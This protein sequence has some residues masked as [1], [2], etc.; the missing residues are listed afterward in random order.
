MASLRVVAAF[1][2]AVLL[3]LL[4]V[5]SAGLNGYFGTKSRYE[6]VNPYLVRDPLSLGPAAVGSGLPPSCA[7]LQLRAL[8]RHG[9]RYP[10][11]EQIRRLGDLHA[12]LLRRRPAAD[13]G[14]AAAACPVAADLA[15]W[16]MWY[17]ESLD[18]RLAPQG[19]RDME[20]L[21]RRLAAR[22][23]ALFAARRRLVLASSS[24]HRCLQS[25]AAFRRGLGP[26]F[27][28]G[29]DE[30]E[31]EVND[32][33]MRFFD[34]CA[35]F[36]A[37]VEEN[38]TAM[39]QVKA[40]KEGPEMKKVVEKVASALCLPVE[41]LNADLVQVAFLT[42]SYELAIK[43]VT[44][45]W[46]SLFSEEDAKVLEYLNDL[47]QYWKRGYGYDINSRSSCILFQDIFQHLDKA[48]EESKSSKPISSPVIVQVGHAETLQPLLA[49]MGFFKDDE[50]LKANNYIRQAHRK[51]RTGRIVPYA[52]N[53]VFVLYHCDQVKNPE[54]EYQVQMLL[55]EKLMLFQHSNE[56]I[57][58]Y[59]DLKDYY[60][61]IL[62]NCHFKE[63]CELPKVNNTAIDE[64]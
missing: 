29:S 32:S 27:S 17:N 51:F 18:G 52:A 28:L 2:S 34:H 62:E 49:L 48:V 5:A 24:K 57:S 11:A 23:P 22:F 14:S 60:K 53:L 7:P 39:C 56:T 8:L 12:R 38:A 13:A 37:L 43:N 15:A 47:K 21:A 19:R 6:D 36:V 26:S 9:T 45:P 20:H 40:F 63:E 3:P 50:P 35:K 54:E 4:E 55:N 59:A 64:L 16:Q 46:C 25:G 10:T 30:A 31:V 42:C 33:L 58:T 44:S 1:L 61:N 41:E